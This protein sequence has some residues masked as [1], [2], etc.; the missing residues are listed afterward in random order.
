MTARDGWWPPSRPVKAS[1]AF[2]LAC[3]CAAAGAQSA[4]RS[5]RLQ[6][7]LQS[8]SVATRTAAS[9][10][11]FGAGISDPALYATVAAV[12]QRGMA[13]GSHSDAARID[14]LAWHAEALGGSGDRTY[15][16]LLQQAAQSPRHA[17]ARH[18]RDA[19]ELLRAMVLEGRPYLDADH[20]RL[21]AADA[22]AACRFFKKTECDAREAEDCE[23]SLREESARVGADALVVLARQDGRASRHHIIANAYRC[24]QPALP[25]G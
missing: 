20:V 10:A 15:L 11:I 6:A 25:G 13:D 12:L 1:V 24:P 2:L 8:D 21:V 22:V 3:A 17:L 16:P 14:E 18:A 19:I 9:R 7:A 23:E 4:D 5:A